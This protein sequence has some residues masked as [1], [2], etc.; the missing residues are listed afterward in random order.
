MPACSTASRTPLAQVTVAGAQAVDVQLPDSTS[1]LV[2]FKLVSKDEVCVSNAYFYTV[3]D[4]ERI[5]PVN[6]AVSTTT[7]R[8]EEDRKSVV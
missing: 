3:V 5:R 1:A 7:F 6:L 4:E 8:K 2:G